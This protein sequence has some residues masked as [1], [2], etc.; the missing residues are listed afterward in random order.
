[1][2]PKETIINYWRAWTEHNLENL[3][4]LLAPDYVKRSPGLGPDVG[5][6]EVRQAFKMFDQSLPDLKEEVISILAEGDRV[7]C[8]VVET[9]TFTGPMQMPTGVIEPTNRSYRLPLA[10]FFRVNEQG[11]IVEQRTYF[12]ISDWCRQIGIDPNLLA[13]SSENLSQNE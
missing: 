4:H 1:M 5:K 10:A 9:A 3:L 2:A 7:A 6:D 13:P 12:D 11:L 8:E